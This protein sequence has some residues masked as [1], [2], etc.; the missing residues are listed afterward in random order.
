MK[1]KYEWRYGLILT[2]LA[3]MLVWP[4]RAEAAL[5]APPPPVS[6]YF[7]GWFSDDAYIILRVTFPQDWAW[8]RAGW[9]DARTQVQWQNERGQ[10]RDVDGW[11]GGLDDVTRAADGQ[12]AGVKTW[13]VGKAQRGRGPF[14]W[15][16]TGDLR[17][18]E[19]EP[20]NLPSY[21]GQAVQVE[22]RF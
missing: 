20:F 5:P 21:G 1:R 11:Q 19:S 22:V 4:W 6:E 18:A 14:R 7:G 15:V 2:S 10:W 12:I 13:W 17:R 16:V 8:D 3:V 9:Q